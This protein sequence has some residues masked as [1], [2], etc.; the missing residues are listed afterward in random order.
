MRPSIGVFHQNRIRCA[1]LPGKRQKKPSGVENFVDIHDIGGTD[2]GDYDVLITTWITLKEGTK[3]EVENTPEK[4]SGFMDR[5][6][7]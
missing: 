5:N 2:P 4:V 1:F 7:A 6:S 3:A